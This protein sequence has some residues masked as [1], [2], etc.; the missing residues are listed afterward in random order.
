MAM[1]LK[2]ATVVVAGTD[3]SK[4]LRDIRISMTR[5]EVDVTQIGALG[6]VRAGGAIDA[7]VACSF[8]QD[9]AASQVNGTLEPLF[10]QQAPFS[11]IAS[12]GPRTPLIQMNALLTGYSP[13]GGAVGEAAMA[14]V[15]FQCAD[16][17]VAWLPYLTTAGARGVGAATARAGTISVS[18]LAVTGVRSTASAVGRPGSFALGGDVYGRSTYGSGVYG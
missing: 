13:I 10:R 4:H 9:F 11:L 15:L 12:G 2:D 1:I 18:R 14:P 16:G 5:D 7:T 6:R 17:N 3:L 8:Y